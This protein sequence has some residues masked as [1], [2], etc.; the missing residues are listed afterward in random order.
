MDDVVAITQVM[1]PAKRKKILGV[2]ADGEES[3]KL[4]EVLM[5]MLESEPYSGLI[6]ATR[7]KDSEIQ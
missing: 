3:N 6:S 7:N 4:H 1:S 5:R 2:F